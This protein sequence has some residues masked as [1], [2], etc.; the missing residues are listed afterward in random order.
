MSKV[1]DTSYSEQATSCC[2]HANFFPCWGKLGILN[3]GTST[4]LC[5]SPC[6]PFPARNTSCWQPPCDTAWLASPGLQ[7]ATWAPSQEAEQQI[8]AVAGMCHSHCHTHSLVVFSHQLTVCN[9]AIIP[10]CCGVIPMCLEVRVKSLP[11][12]F[13]VWAKV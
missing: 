9:A 12:H 11:S 6:Q 2:S 7:G 5:G 4:E 1:R 13:V 10:W 8:A 3:P